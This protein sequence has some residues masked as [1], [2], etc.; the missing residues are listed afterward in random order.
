MKK[1]YLYVFLILLNCANYLKGP[2][3]ITKKEAEKQIAKVI[4]LKSLTCGYNAPRSYSISN[5]GNEEREPYSWVRIGGDNGSLNVHYEKKA[6][7]YCLKSLKLMPCPTQEIETDL[8]D[9][10]FIATLILTRYSSCTFK[11]IQFWEINKALNGR[12]KINEKY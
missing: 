5:L 1:I 12:N 7:D 9:K 3:T 4:F 11:P 8:G 6:L 10:E 2:N